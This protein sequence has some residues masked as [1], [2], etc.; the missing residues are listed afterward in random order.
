MWHIVFFLNEAKTSNKWNESWVVHQSLNFQ[1]FLHTT[2]LVLD[3]LLDVNR[4]RIFTIQSRKTPVVRLQPRLDFNSISVE[5][6]A[7]F[8]AF[9][10]FDC[11]RW[12]KI[13]W[14]GLN[15]TT[16]ITPC[17]RCSRL[18][19]NA[20][21]WRL[22]ISFYVLQASMKIMGT[23]MS[24]RVCTSGVCSMH[25][26]CQPTSE[27]ATVKYTKLLRWLL[28]LLLLQ[29]T[30]S[31]TMYFMHVCWV[32]ALL[33]SLLNKQTIRTLSTVCGLHCSTKTM[34]HLHFKTKLITRH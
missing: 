5:K 25:A 6:L 13:V 32:Y 30:Y 34:Y 28:L 8:G 21:S 23:T 27:R 17:C 16:V 3:D 26:C 11:L 29:K 4:I 19:A 33:S 24:K 14:A 7:I 18:R 22:I 15:A 20:W 9:R 10:L 31:I 1:S 12:W 2:K